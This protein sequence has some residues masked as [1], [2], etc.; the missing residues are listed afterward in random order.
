MRK[1]EKENGK[2]NK[3]RKKL[4][5]REEKNPMEKGKKNRGKKEERRD[6]TEEG[7]TRK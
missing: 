1:E 5:T 2:M 4:G 6:E 7:K 3:R